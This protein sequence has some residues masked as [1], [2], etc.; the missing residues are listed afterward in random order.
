[1]ST[2]IYIST[3]T[4]NELAERIAA[5]EPCRY[6][7]RVTP[8]QVKLAFAEADIWPLSILLDAALNGHA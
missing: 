5:L 1:M 8:D 4:F 2:N 6:S 3:R 7:G